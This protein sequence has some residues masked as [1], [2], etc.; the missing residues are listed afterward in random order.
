MRL[1]RSF[2]GILLIF[3]AI[4]TGLQAQQPGPQ[5]Q[6][7]QANNL[8]AQNKFSDAAAAYQRLI[9]AGYKQP[10]LYFNAGNA[11]YK[12]NR[13]G[14]AVFSYEKALQFAPGNASIEHNLALA[15]QKVV[16]YL[17]ELPMVFFQRWWIQL[18]H[19]HST[20]GWA[21]GTI[22]FFWL[23]MAGIIA[24]RVWPQGKNKWFRWAT[25]AAGVFFA[26]YLTMAISTYIIDNNHHTGIIMNSGIKAKAAPDDNSKDAFEVQEGMK[27]QIANTTKE[28]CKIQLADGKT[29]WV[30]CNNIKAL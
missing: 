26:F 6:F 21:I 23:L 25:T 18:E 14:M 7:E 19:F 29:G 15:N 1:L 9:D 4:H 11:Y 16:G 3:L 2:T 13:T 20:N 12:T 8:Y 28:Y 27:V 17:Q 30:P 24:F 10:S 22:V 5:Q